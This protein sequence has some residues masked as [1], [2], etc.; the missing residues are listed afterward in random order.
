MVK[1]A[2]DQI[3]KAN[4]ILGVAGAASEF[5]IALR[6]VMDILAKLPQ[7]A[8]GQV[9]PGAQNAAQQQFMMEQRQQQATNPIL[10]QLAAQRG[11]QGGGAA[12]PGGA[13]PGPG[14]PSPALAGAG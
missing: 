11:G 10:A 8:A 4:A 3:V 13:P 2:Y 7:M 12:P 1:G 9:P 14:G 5:G 6:K